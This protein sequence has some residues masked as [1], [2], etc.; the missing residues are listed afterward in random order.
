MLGVL[1]FSAGVLIVYVDDFKLAGP[2]KHLPEGW[3]L[4]RNGIITRE[5]EP[6]GR[7]LRC[8]HRVLEALIPASGSPAHG[9][10][11]EPP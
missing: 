5:A 10:V 7:Y 4:I 1:A 8:E 2:K 6:T 3:T 11:P 9:E